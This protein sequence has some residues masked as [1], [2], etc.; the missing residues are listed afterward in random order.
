MHAG[1]LQRYFGSERQWRGPCVVVLDADASI[2]T[3]GSDS[4]MQ[5]G[6]KSFA[7]RLISGRVA[8]DTACLLPEESV[9][10]LVQAQR[11]RQATGEDQHQQTLLVVDLAH[12]AAVEFTNLDALRAF[13]VPEPQ[14]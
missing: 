4:I 13:D 14:K 7:P 5:S 1:V 8:A 10:L 3:T 9:L 2:Q 12:V 6:M 11:I